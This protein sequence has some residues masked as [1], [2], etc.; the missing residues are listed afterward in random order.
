MDENNFRFK[1]SEMKFKKIK[2]FCDKKFKSDRM[3]DILDITRNEE[4]IKEYNERRN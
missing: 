1:S 4:I 2:S 3:I